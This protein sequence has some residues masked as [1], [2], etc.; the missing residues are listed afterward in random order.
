[1]SPHKVECPNETQHSSS[2]WPHEDESPFLPENKVKGHLSKKGGG[3]I[4]TFVYVNKH[5]LPIPYDSQ[6][7]RPI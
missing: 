1:M 2:E 3:L 7:E 4:S 6:H 5:C